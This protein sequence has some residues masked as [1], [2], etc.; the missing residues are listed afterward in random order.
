MTVLISEMIDFMLFLTDSTSRVA[1][2]TE[3]KDFLRTKFTFPL[4]Y[5][6]RDV[7]E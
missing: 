7:T 5:T 2:M 3:K 1:F 4:N 6:Y